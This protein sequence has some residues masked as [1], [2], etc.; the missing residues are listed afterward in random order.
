MYS[1]P[2]LHSNTSAI[3]QKGRIEQIKLCPL[4]L[5]TGSYGSI[6]N[7]REN[8]RKQKKVDKNGTSYD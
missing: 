2:S 6:S 7:S 1:I 5:Q 3:M 8:F 4:N